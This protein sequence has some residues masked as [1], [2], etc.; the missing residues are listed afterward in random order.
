[1]VAQLI[2]GSW[3]RTSSAGSNISSRLGQMV[4]VN[5]LAHSFTT[6]NTCYKV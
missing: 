5:N 4:S 1:M 2:L 3:S 6:F